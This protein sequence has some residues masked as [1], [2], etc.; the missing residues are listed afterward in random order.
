MRRK[1]REITDKREILAIVQECRVLRLAM[2]DETGLPYL[3]PL[4]FGYRFENDTFTFYFHSAR[5]GRKL[6][7][8]RRDGRVAF[9]MDCRGEL[10]PSDHAC[11]FGYY[12]ASVI[13]SGTA[14]EVF[15]EEKLEGL[16]LL[17]RHMAG[18]DDRFTPE[19][20]EGVAVF[21]VRVTS[22]TAKAKPHKT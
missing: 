18:R 11:G 15:G 5:E 21:A 10:Q 13:G 19:M 6:D 22:L 2:L 1:D 20:A 14:E 7:L 4:N 12:Y 16:T 9:E 8:L 3:I 17:M